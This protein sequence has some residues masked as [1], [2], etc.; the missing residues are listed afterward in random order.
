[1]HE[2]PVTENILKIVLEEGKKHNVQKI[3]KIKIKIGEL[4]D[5]VPDCI[6]Y[7]FALFS[8]GS[9]AQEA[10]IEI[11]K[12]PLKVNCN[13]CGILSEI[14]IKSFRCPKCSSQDLKIISGREFY[15]D[16]MEV[17]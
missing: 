7:Y 3:S 17:D 8:K 13:S 6:N 2:L 14:D 9:I 4:S 15:I 11:E 5:L 16:S 12:L 10:I 1:M